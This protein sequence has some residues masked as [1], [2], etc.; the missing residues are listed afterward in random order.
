MFAGLPARPVNVGQM[1]RGWNKKG[2]LA[3]YAD[4]KK[5]PTLLGDEASTMSHELVH[6]LMERRDLADRPRPKRDVEE[7]LARH[8]AGNE[9][10]VGTLQRNPNLARYARD[11]DA[12]LQLEQTMPPW[13]HWLYGPMGLMGPRSFD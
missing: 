4:P 10:S 8:L 6:E 12:A 11:W 7:Q 3:N 5:T 9:S 1:D 2:F 13:M